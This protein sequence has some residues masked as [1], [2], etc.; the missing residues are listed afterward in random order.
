MYDLAILIPSR[1]EE[2]LYK[3][4]QDLLEH[5]TDATEIIVG[6]DGTSEYMS[7]PDHKDVK[8]FYV[9]EAIG[10]RAI[11]KQL[12]R[13]S[14]AKYIAKVDAHCAFD[15]KFDVKMLDAFKITGDNVVMAPV[16]RNLHVFDWVCEDGH[17]RYQGPSG[18]CTICGK[19]TVKDVKWIAKTNPQS[20]AYCFDSE[21]HFQYMNDLKKRQSYISQ[22]DLT[23]SMSLQGSFF[24]M[25]K[26]KYFE[27]DV[28]DE[29]LGMWGSQGISVACRFWLSGGKVLINH[30]TFYAH[31]FRTQGQDF[32]FPYPQSGKQ[33]SHAKAAVRDL[34]FNNKW[35]KAIHPLSW[36][37]EKFAPVPGWT[38]ADIAKLKGE[39]VEVAKPLSKGILYYTDNSMDESIMKLCQEQIKSSINGHKLV[40]ISQKPIDFGENTVVDLERS[41]KSMFIQILEGLK[42]LDT[43]VVFLCEHDLLYHPTHFI[44]TPARKDTFYYNTNVWFL[45]WNDGH[46]LYYG[47]TQL[48]GLC[49]YRESLITHFTERVKMIDEIGFSRHMGFEPMTHGRIKWENQYRFEKWQSEFPNVDIKHGKNQLRARWKKEEFRRVPDVWIDSEEIP[50]WGKGKELISGN[51]L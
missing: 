10:Q 28:D 50:F 38:D 7:V 19:E 1:N 6:L 48:S 24:M 35:E 37:L 31:C 51:R 2:W 20:V 49:A 9:Y 36:L 15:D 30:N 42:K 26:D 12:A 44:F 46:C 14:T 29:S 17:T 45:R 40:S 25:T 33:V 3:T 47:A 21:P 23:E 41:A 11:T 34:F 4:I 22:G 39:P 13:L 27:L 8:V 16:M 43:D 32:G 5:K 18:L